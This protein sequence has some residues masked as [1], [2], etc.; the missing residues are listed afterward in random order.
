M[1]NVPDV[2]I[3][4]GV[5]DLWENSTKPATSFQCFP[6]ETVPFIADIAGYGLSHGQC[7]TETLHIGFHL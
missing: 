4:C 7:T 1:C 2:D 5:K 6:I 3:S